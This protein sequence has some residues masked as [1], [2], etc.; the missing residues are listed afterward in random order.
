MS[1]II[2]SI[3]FFLLNVSLLSSS[4]I[5]I[6]IQQ[7][8]NASPEDRVRLMNEFKKALREMNSN[9]R[10]KAIKAIQAKQN[11]NNIQNNSLQDN[12]QQVQS[13]SKQIGE[14]THQIDNIPLDTIQNTNNNIGGF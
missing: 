4:D 10:I 6:K 13:I 8:Q 2:I 7:I 5:D 1:K 11:I 9:N 14:V 12:L 3:L